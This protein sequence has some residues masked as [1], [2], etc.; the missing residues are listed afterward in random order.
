MIGY[1]W[2]GS[3]TWS[4]AING[5]VMGFSG[6]VAFYGTPY[7]SGGQRATARRRPFRRP[8]IADS[9]A[10]ISKPVMLLSG[11]KDARI[12]ALMPA[13]DSTM[14]AMHKSLLVHELPWSDPRIPSGAGRSEDAAGRGR[15]AANLAATR[16]AW[17]KTVAF[18]R[19]NLGVK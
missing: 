8:L 5:G 15:E 17:P 12:T 7:T 19:K 3:A 18:L 4:H 11:S 13:I 2:G 6:G 9:V 16:D 14:K 10:K 1:C